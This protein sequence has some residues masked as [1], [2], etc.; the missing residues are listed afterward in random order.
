MRPPVL[1]V[2][3]GELSTP[4]RVAIQLREPRHPARCAPA[5]VRRRAAEDARS[6]QR[7]RHFRRAAERQRRRRDRAS[8]RSTGSACRSRRRSRFSASASARRCWPSG[9]A[10]ASTSTPTATPRS[11]T[12]RSGRPPTGRAVCKDWPDHVYQWHREGFD[13]PDKARDAGRG[14]FVSGAGLQLRRHRLRAAIPH[15]RHP[16]H[17]VPLD[18]ARPRAHG[19]AQRQA[20]R[21]A[22]RG[23]A[24]ARPGL[25]GLAVRVH[26]SLAQA[27]DARRDRPIR[28]KP[29]QPKI[30]PPK[31]ARANGGGGQRRAVSRV[32]TR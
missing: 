15:G 3:H 7:R 11:A 10:P 1:I 14:R 30:A 25:P 20:A 4:G 26:R 23:P 2:L 16:R 29:R 8:A 17:D 6:T 22:F 12:T 5:A 9:S 21:N 18:H 19:A 32:S 24:D 28:R 13:L 27:A 31:P